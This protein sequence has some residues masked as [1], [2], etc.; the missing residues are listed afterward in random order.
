VL[1]LSKNKWK[2]H[3]FLL[4]AILEEELAL[5]TWWLPDLLSNKIIHQKRI[6]NKLIT[7]GYLERFKKVY[8]TFLVTIDE[9][10]LHHRTPG[11]KQ[12]S[13]Q[14]KPRWFVVSK[15]SKVSFINSKITRVQF[16]AE[17][18]LI[19]IWGCLAIKREKMDK[20]PDG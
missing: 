4:F 13:K 19:L 20:R 12:H 17:N 18:H 9:T 14:W 8:N 15:D 3:L 1:K 10:W 6:Y 5:K 11:T 7:Q 2:L 16:L